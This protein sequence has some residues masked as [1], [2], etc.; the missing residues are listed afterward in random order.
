MVPGL[1]PPL[2]GKEMLALDAG[3]PPTHLL[4]T[5]PQGLRAVFSQ[6]GAALA[7]RTCIPA[8]PLC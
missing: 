4:L 8:T 6:P 5:A 1:W 3:H 2:R 7:T